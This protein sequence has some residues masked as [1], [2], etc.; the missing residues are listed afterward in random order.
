MFFDFRGSIMEK[1]PEHTDERILKIA[2][3]IKELRISL[4]YTSAENFAFDHD[5]NRVQY[6]RVENGANITLK[7]LLKILDIHKLSL[8]EFFSMF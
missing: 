4:G 6:W 2:R 1:Q 3:K 8:N 5:L 7:T